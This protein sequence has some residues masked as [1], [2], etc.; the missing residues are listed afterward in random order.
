M[1]VHNSVDRAGFVLN[2]N[3]FGEYTSIRAY[4]D[5]IYIFDLLIL[6]KRCKQS[7]WEIVTLTF[8][9][10]CLAKK[11][12]SLSSTESRGRISLTALSCGELVTLSS[13]RSSML[14]HTHGT[15]SRRSGARHRAAV[16][17]SLKDWW[18]TGVLLVA[19]NAS[20]WY[21]IS[22]ASSEIT[23]MSAEL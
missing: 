15:R 23:D 4:R 20:V 1:S 16:T 6:S 2:W 3:I 5:G 9:R 17:Q 21:R 7:Y 10:L 11:L 19:W 12:L 18:R 14:I 13:L 22:A 8:F